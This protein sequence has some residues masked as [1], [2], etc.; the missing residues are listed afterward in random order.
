MEGILPIPKKNEN[1][2]DF[3]N[4]CIP[5]VIGEGREKNQAI[6]ICYSIWDE[7][8]KKKDY[9]YNDSDILNMIENLKYLRG[10]K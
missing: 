2:S 3:I 4:R 5:Q 1:Q 8:K 6:A 9:H 10:R 7:S